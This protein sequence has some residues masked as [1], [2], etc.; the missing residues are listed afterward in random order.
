MLEAVAI[1]MI[2]AGERVHR[3]GRGIAAE[4]R[5]QPLAQRLAVQESGDLEAAQLEA[6]NSRLQFAL[7]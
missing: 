2:G 1:D 5:M 6:V 3:L 4:I 7:Q